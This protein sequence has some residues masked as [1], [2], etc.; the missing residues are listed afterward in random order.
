[1]QTNVK[2][3]KKQVSK[4]AKQKTHTDRLAIVA[5]IKC[6]IRSKLSIDID[7]Y[8][9]EGLQTFARILNDYSAPILF[10]GFSGKIF[11]KEIDRYLCYILPLSK[12]VEHS[13]SIQ[14]LGHE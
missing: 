7:M 5:D 11:I 1:M 14:G 10:S 2:K 4:A 12:H 13:V 9:S 8:E 3:I 6:Q